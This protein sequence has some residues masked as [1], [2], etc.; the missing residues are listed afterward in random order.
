MRML[1]SSTKLS[2]H[3]HLKSC[4]CRRR[5]ALAAEEQYGK[6]AADNSDASSHSHVETAGGGLDQDMGTDAGMQRTIPE[7]S[8]GAR[9][10]A[11]EN[12][13][14]A[15]AVLQRRMYCV[16]PT[17]PFSP[18]LFGGNRCVDRR[19][20]LWLT[21]ITVWFCS[22]RLRFRDALWLQNLPA[23][24]SGKSYFIW[25]LAICVSCHGFLLA[26]IMA[27]SLQEDRLFVYF[28]LISRC[29]VAELLLTQLWHVQIS[30][31]AK[32]GHHGWIFRLQL[33]GHAMV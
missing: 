7:G 14:P 18:T 26:L 23:C 2:G 6:D 9:S 20:Q 1:H 3:L 24:H 29:Q 21:S 10:I 28:T 33:A 15:L 30:C 31:G 8:R 12:D 5:A 4:L 19:A 32:F 27:E 25:Q 17:S 11:S 13:S 22:A 16:C